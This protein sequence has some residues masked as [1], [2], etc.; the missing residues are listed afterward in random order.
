MS[1][2]QPTWSKYQF[3]NVNDLEKAKTLYDEVK[4]IS[5]DST[6]EEWNQAWSPVL[7]YLDKGEAF[8]LIAAKHLVH[9]APNGKG[10]K[11]FKAFKNL[12]LLIKQLGLG[13]KPCQD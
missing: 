1:Y 2:W 7:P 4:H 11:I 6:V 8:S 5:R 13:K 3:L 12:S 9:N 10:K